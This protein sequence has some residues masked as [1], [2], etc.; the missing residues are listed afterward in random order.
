MSAISSLSQS[1]DHFIEEYQRIHQGLSIEFDPQWP[2]SCYQQQAK[3]GQMVAWRPILRESPGDFQS[4]E[5]ALNIQ[6][7]PQLKEFF[8]RY[9]SDNL[10]AKAPQGN[11]Q[12]LQA[13]NADD[14]EQLQQNLVGHIL[15]KRRL[16]QPETAFF[17]LTDEEDFI[18]SVELDSGQVVLE[19]VG[20]LPQQVLAKDLQSFITQLTPL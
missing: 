20:L 6:L 10:N 4:M 8:G 5:R 16:K 2:S 12:L 18:L 13:W 19:Q 14:F 15:M 3:A 17:A 9:W 7:D 1:F 11:L